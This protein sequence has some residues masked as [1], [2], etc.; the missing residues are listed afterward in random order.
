M[1]QPRS[2][3]P[4][5]RLLDIIGDRWS[6]LILRDAIVLR[7]RRYG[8]FLSSP[9]GIS[10]N[11]LANRL[12]KLVKHGLLEKHRDPN[13]GRS[14]IYLPTDEGLALTPIL[15]EVLRWGS[16]GLSRENL[17]SP[18]QRLFAQTYDE[19]IADQQDV[20]SKERSDLR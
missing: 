20:I 14:C 1:N 9:E 17:P 2:P 19:Y 13:S 4:I 3:C 5:A 10:T 15:S 11:V 7:K 18:M 16:R 12:K 6:L 8:D